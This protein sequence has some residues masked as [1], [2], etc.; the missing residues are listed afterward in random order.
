MYGL[1]PGKYNAVLRHNLVFSSLDIYLCSPLH[2]MIVEKSS[3]PKCPQKTMQIRLYEASSILRAPKSNKCLR[4]LHYSRLIHT[5]TDSNCPIIANIRK[6]F[7][8]IYVLRSAGY[9]R[10]SKFIRRMQ[11]RLRHKQL[12]IQVNRCF[13]MFFV[14]ISTF[15]IADDRRF[16]QNTH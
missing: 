2:I 13:L 3:C 7:P 5:D 1:E 12:R 9:T 10:I 4:W 16:S 11:C 8:Q 14:I 6:A 15:W